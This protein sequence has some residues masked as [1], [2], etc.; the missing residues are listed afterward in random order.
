MSD[1]DSEEPSAKR[2]E[3]GEETEKHEE[4]VT[5]EVDQPPP[6]LVPNEVVPDVSDDSDDG[7]VD[8]DRG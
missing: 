1:S 7:V 6:V 4:E 5:K 8:S 2:A 3:S